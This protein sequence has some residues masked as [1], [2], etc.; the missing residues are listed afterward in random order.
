MWL[1]QSEGERGRRGG[2]GGD[3]DRNRPCRAFRLQ[4]G[5]GLLSQGAGNPGG[6]W[7]EGKGMPRKLTGCPL[8]ATRRTDWGML[9]TPAGGTQAEALV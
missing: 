9:W 4:E 8:A 6:L 7:A 2:Q 1:E 3:R 5:L